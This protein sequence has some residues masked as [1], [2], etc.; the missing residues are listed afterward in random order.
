MATIKVYNQKGEVVGE[1]K[2]NPAIFD[3]AIKPGVVQQAVIAQ[4]AN[5]R[6]AIAHAKDRSEVAGGGRKPWRQ[7][8]T[9][10]ARHGSTRSPLWR[11][12]GVTFGPSSKQNFKIKIN[13][14]AK[15]KALAMCLTDKVKGE[16]LLALDKLEIADGKTKNFFAVLQNLKLR[17]T[18]T[19]KKP[20]E[21]EKTDKKP[22]AKKS[23][24]LAGVLV[25]LPVVDEAVKRSAR[26]VP[27]IKV[28]TAN[29]LNVFEL[30][31]YQYV[32]A[33]V[34]ALKKIEEVFTTK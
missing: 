7:K 29:S 6:V 18:V 25:V 5:A 26:N 17:D 8:G 33:S 24:K 2:L 13:K 1:E 15:Q 11:G 32:V 9:G 28:T 14:K 30:L 23:K 3:V 19:K 12:G 20:A 4:T 34:G 21:K 16:K 10:R 27:A 22:A 31:K